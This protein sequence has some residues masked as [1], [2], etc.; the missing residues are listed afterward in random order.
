M[1]VFLI[2]L[3]LLVVVLSN[4]YFFNFQKSQEGQDERGKLILYK[5]V[6]S[7]Y[8]ALFVGSVVL[9]VLNLVDIVN[10]ETTIELLMYFLIFIGV[11][12]TFLLYR[13]KN[14]PM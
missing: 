6:S 4:M 11:Y 5:T 9:I 12:G 2:A 3:L 14:K 8:N 7:M 10:A 1:I 13:N